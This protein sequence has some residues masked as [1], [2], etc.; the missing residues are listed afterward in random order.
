MFVLCINCADHKSIHINSYHSLT[1]VIFCLGMLQDVR[2]FH[3]CFY[4]CHV[5]HIR[6]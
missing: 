6:I 2:Y 5:A 3:L 1:D 4:I